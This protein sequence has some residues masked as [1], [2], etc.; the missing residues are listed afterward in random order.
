MTRGA[1][2]GEAA[3]PSAPPTDTGEATGLPGARLTITIGYGPS[4]FD[5]RLGLSGRKPAA[6]AAAAA[7]QREP[8][9]GLVRR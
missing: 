9:P 2:G 3:E 5:G 4:L 6:L 7:G 1:A 8:R